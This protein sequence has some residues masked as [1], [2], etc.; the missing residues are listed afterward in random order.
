MLEQCKTP[1]SLFDY[2]FIKHEYHHFCL[3]ITSV[4]SSQSLTSDPDIILSTYQFF[5]T[6][7][8]VVPFM[9]LSFLCI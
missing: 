3:S 7:Y 4:L 2:V 8:T 5:D 9:L 6:I 1:D